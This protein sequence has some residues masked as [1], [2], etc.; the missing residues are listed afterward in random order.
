MMQ[1]S[2][3]KI[4]NALYI[5]GDIY[6]DDLGEP[7][8]AIPQYEDLI[9]RYPQDAVAVQSC[10]TL[11]NIYRKM[12]NT[13]MAE[14]YR[15]MILRDYPESVYAKVMTNPD[16]IRQ[17]EE[18]E[19]EVTNFYEAAYSKYKNGNFKETIADCDVAITKY[20]K[21]PLLTKLSLIHI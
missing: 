1:A 18:K 5:S 17:L 20:S 21:H 3:E 13:P 10:Y 11:Y 12:N 6:N 19:K 8:L 9:K 15:E 7:K 2:H 14:R 16:Y 4:K